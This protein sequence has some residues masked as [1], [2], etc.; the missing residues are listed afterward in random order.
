MPQGILRYVRLFVH[1][2]KNEIKKKILHLIHR[3]FAETM[4]R[5]WVL[6]QNHAQRSTNQCVVLMEELTK[7][8]V[9]SAEQPCEQMGL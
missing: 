8:A 4:R 3:L 5:H 1:S 7:T 9:N 6:I 2:V